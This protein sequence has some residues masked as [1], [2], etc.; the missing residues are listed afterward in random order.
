MRISPQRPGSRTHRQGVV[1]LDGEPERPGTL[2]PCVGQ[3]VSRCKRH[4]RAMPHN[5]LH[6]HFG[7]DVGAPLNRDNA[8][9]YVLRAPEVVAAL[10]VITVIEKDRHRHVVA[11]PTGRPT[12]SMLPVAEPHVPRDHSTDDTSSFPV[13]RR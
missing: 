12:A 2:D 10:V 9:T 11:D 4:P 8:P 1:G 6:A 7:Y 3:V 5:S 13:H